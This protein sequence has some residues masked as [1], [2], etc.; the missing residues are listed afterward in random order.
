[1][2]RS[3]LFLVVVALLAGCGGG[4]S[5]SAS[6]EE[7][8]NDP[9]ARMNLVL[10]EVAGHKIYGADVRYHMERTTGPTTLET[11]LQN[12]D[13]VGVAL[14]ALVDQYVWAEM[15]RRDGYKLTDEEKRKL[16]AHETEFLATRY[17]AEVVVPKAEPSEK[18]VETFYL[19]HQENY[20]APARVAV[21][22]ILVSTEAEARQMVQRA[23]AG[24]DFAELAKTYSADPATRE[25]GGALGFVQNG[26]EILG[27]GKSSVFEDAVLPLEPG[28]MNVVKTHMGWHAVKV[29]QK[30]GGGVRPFDEVEPEIKDLLTRRE[31]GLV[32]NQELESARDKTN[33]RVF[34]EVF[35]QFTGQAQNCER[36]MEM[37]SRHPEAEGRAE[38]YRRVAFEFRD[39]DEAPRAQFMI[40]YVRF[41]EMENPLL[42]RKALE[43]L[44]RE[45]PDSEWALAGRLLL[46]RLESDP[47]ELG[48]PEEILAEATS[49]GK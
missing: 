5:N 8:S 43:R 40:A 23:I 35:G 26:S 37:A 34:G 42:A 38:L 27:I 24:E 44:E 46:S 28:Q 48:T 41:K 19:E 36:L 3:W 49:E 39:C 16:Y 22:H 17:V 21:R 2:K 30:E 13:I 15:A 32:L 31:V 12:P 25:L 45:F 47:D 11:Y 33:T 29:E 1:M 7:G 9:D 10:A 14:A 18:E 4:G 6:S 20:L